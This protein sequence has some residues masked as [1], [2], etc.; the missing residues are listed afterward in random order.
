MAIGIRGNGDVCIEYS[1]NQ[2]SADQVGLFDFAERLTV[3]IM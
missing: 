1:L 2:A 3:C